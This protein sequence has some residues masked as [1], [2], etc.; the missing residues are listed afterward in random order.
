MEGNKREAGKFKSLEQEPV[1][2][3][4]NSIGRL[5]VLLQ[6]NISSRFLE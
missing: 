5:T 4:R 2:F 1:L 3:G 6:S